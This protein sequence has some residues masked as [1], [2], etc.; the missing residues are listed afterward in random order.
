[1]FEASRSLSLGEVVGNNY[2]ILGIVGAGGMGVVYRALDRKLQRTVALK[3]LPPEID[4][5]EREREYFLLE[6]RTASS[7]DHPNIGVIH[8]I[9]ETTDGRAFIVM[10]FYA[11]QSLGQIL[12]NGPLPPAKAVEIACQIAKGLQEAHSRKIVHRDI[13][14]TNVM[15]TPSGALKIV[16]F[17]LAR[18]I[19]GESATVTGVTGTVKYMSPEQA[20]GHR[21]DQRTDIWSLGVV[22]EEM[23]TGANPFERNTVSAIL[24]AVLHEPPRPLDGVPLELQSIVY[25]ALSKNPEKRYQNCSEMLADLEA[26]RTEAAV[27]PGTQREASKGRSTAKSS[28]I[29]KYIEEASTSAWN[30]SEPPRNRSLPWLL[31]GIGAVAVASLLFFPALS[32]KIRQLRSGGSEK[33]VAVLPFENAGNNPEDTA[34]VDGLLDSLAGKLSNLDVDNKALWVIPTSEVRRLKVTDPATALK[35]FGATYVVSGSVRRDG[36]GVNLSLN[37]ID[38]RNLRLIGSADVEDQGGD[39]ATLEDQAVSR[40]ARLMNLSVSAGTMKSPGGT[41]APAAYEDYLTALGYMQRYDKPGNLDLAVTALQNAIQTDPSFAL[42]RAQL[43]EAYRF[44]Y[45]VDQNPRW[46]N[47]A[48]ANG[49]KAVELDSQLPAAYITLGWVHEATGKHDLALQEFQQA[50]HLDPL[51]GL[52]LAGLARSYRR[53]GRIADAE[54]TYQRAIALRSNDWDAYNNYGQFSRNQGKYA[55]AIVQYQ[56]ALQLTPDN[57]Q[58]LGNLGAAYIDAGDPKQFPMAE[59]S[60]KQAI[61]VAP[62]YGAYANLGVLYLRESR[63]QDSAAASEKALSLN[64]KNPDV[65]TNLL[66]CDDW[67]KVPE[68]SAEVRRHVIVLL[69]QAVQLN[70]RD[71]NAHATLA[72]VY[73]AEHEKEKSLSNIQ[74]ALALTPN[75]TDT[76]QNVA[77]SYELLGDRRQ[78]VLYVGKALKAGLKPD[79]LQTDPEIQGAL[80]DPALRSVLKR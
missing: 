37:L 13:K 53:S 49:R 14:P 12:S 3:F 27:E 46:L 60:L 48:E 9:E 51:N 54:A 11:G 1:M 39:L 78:A 79:Q 30:G 4:R 44:K 74:I 73:A 10:A 65:W 24:V 42:G 57:A 26:Y 68:K 33:H 20:M 71:A 15:I 64:D 55:Q 72:T 19:S 22:L 7:L 5:D 28:D 56:K 21:V 40:L 50:L 23:L 63:F 16:D 80:R 75:D 45:I 6:A 25:R 77:D 70:S 38:T 32:E 69:E 2:E 67:L 61:K 47:E 17:G 29:R 52:A 36:K 58:V 41:V 18:I 62:S 31:A 66:I 43:G 59:E 34:L 76:L 35:D 8:G